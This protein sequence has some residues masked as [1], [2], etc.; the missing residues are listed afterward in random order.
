MRETGSKRREKAGGRDKSSKEPK[1]PKEAKTAPEPQDVEMPE[2]EAANAAKQPK[3]QDSLTL[4]DIKEHVKQI[5]KAVSGKE[6]RFVLRALRAL[7][8]TSRRLN[9][10]VLHKALTGF[11]TSN[12]TTRDFL[13]GFLEEPMEMADGDIQFRPRTGKAAS[14][15]LLPEVETYLQL[16]LV[17]HLTNSKRYTEILTPGGRDLYG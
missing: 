5:E 7:P 11:F 16:L 17:I 2:E 1:E 14:A 15:P 8:S 10:N 3:E 13:V 12:A 9:T 4:E 6:P